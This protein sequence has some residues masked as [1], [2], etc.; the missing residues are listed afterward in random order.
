MWCTC[1]KYVVLFSHNECPA[2]ITAQT[3]NPWCP[4]PDNSLI[5]FW[6]APTLYCQCVCFQT[7]STMDSMLLSC[8]CMV[9]TDYLLL[10]EALSFVG[11]PFVMTWSA[12]C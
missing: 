3:V 6:F 11:D 12:L 1:H 9:T 5:D 4:L 8:V 7:H 2:A 10:H